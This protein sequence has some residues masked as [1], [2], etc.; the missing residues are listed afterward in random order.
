M[1]SR[2]HCHLVLTFCFWNTAQKIL[3]QYISRIFPAHD[4]ISTVTRRQWHVLT[5]DL[6]KGRARGWNKLVAARGRNYPSGR[7]R[8]GLVVPRAH[9]TGLL[10]ASER[11][12]PMT[13]LL[14]ST[15]R[16][17]STI[18]QI[19]PPTANCGVINLYTCIQS[20]CN[21]ITLP[22]RC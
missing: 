4:S 1:W 13:E 17:I 9:C 8:P 21:R 22:L 12:S 15:V 16:C 19:S 2:I 10:W 3:L 18:Y 6:W 7:H 5:A 20:P 14:T 11:P